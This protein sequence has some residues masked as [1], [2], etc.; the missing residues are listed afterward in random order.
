MLFNSLEFPLFLLI[1]LVLYQ[2][3]QNIVYR[4]YLLLGASLFFYGYWHWPFLF[5]LVFT[6]SIDYW[7]AL[8]ISKQKEKTTKRNYLLVSLAA[9]LSILIYFKYSGFL[10]RTFWYGTS[11]LPSWLDVILPLGISFYTFQAIGYVVDVYRNRLPAEK[12]YRSFLLFITFFPQLVAGPIERAPHLLGQLKSLPQDGPF[13]PMNGIWLILAGF[14]KKILIADR[15]GV[16][17]D[18]VYNSPNQATVP[19]FLTATLF[20]GFQIYCDFS[21]YSDIARGLASFFGVDLM[22]NF[23]K[24]YFA[25]SL[26]DF[27]R[28]WHISLSGWFR[29]YVYQPLGGNR[30]GVTRTMI[31]LL[32]VFCLSGIWH[33]ANTTFLAWGMWHGCGLVGERFILKPERQPSANSLKS[34]LHRLLFLVWTF[35]GWAFF[36]VNSMTDLQ[37]L[38]RHWADSGSWTWEN[39][40]LFHSNSELL[41]SMTAIGLLLFFESGNQEKAGNRLW[42]NRIPEPVLLAGAV[43]ILLW[44][45]HFKG[46]DFIYFQF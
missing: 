18:G 25:W 21:G 30:I 42:T 16:Y 15:L 2:W 8:Q 28:R 29:D 38:L 35:A 24:P 27:W 39:F 11:T 40:N 32:L 31:N 46:Q 10:A 20:F 14:A 6:S 5:L 26:T 23:N 7:A 33:G 45:G 13:F 43:F 36:R 1:V 12:S 17:V 44:F 4:Q 37:I 22:K 41:V 19:Q 9:N 3:I 34:W